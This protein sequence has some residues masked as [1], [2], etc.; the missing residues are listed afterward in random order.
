MKKF[1]I[2]IV[3]FAI[4]ILAFAIIIELNLRNIPNNYSYKSNYLDSNSRNVQILFLG[5]SHAY[6]GINPEFVKSN[7]F[8]A[9]MTSQSLDYDLAILEKYNGKWDNLKVIILPVDYFSMFGMLKTG[10]EAWRVKNYNIYYGFN[11]SIS[12][13]DNTEIFSKR[14]TDN[15]KRLIRY[16]TDNKSDLNCTTLGSGTDYNS[17]N[18]QNIVETGKIAAKRHTAKDYRW[19]DRNSDLLASIVSFAKERNIKIILYT[20]PAYKTY[21]ENLDK[22]QLNRTYEVIQK[23]VNSNANVKYY[24]FLNDKSFDRTDF[25]DGDHLNE[26]GAKKM[27]L[28]MDSLI[29]SYR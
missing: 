8:N 3:F 22:N 20:S 18:S 11:S 4:P 10:I 12:F 6:Y 29:K 9:A 2:Y 17:H 19:F 25:Y 15:Y 5:S 27:T 23:I 28:K 13:A 21:I 7:S 24:N 1:I 14:L 16:K 26:I